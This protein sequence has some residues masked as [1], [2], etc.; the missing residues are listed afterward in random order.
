MNFSNPNTGAFVWSRTAKDI[1]LANAASGSSILFTVLL[2]GTD[3]ASFELTAISGQVTLRFREILEAVLPKGDDSQFLSSSSFRYSNSVAIR[4]ELDGSTVTTASMVCFRGGSD[5][6]SPAFPH[7]SHW[8]TWKPQVTFTWAWAREILSC[9]IPSSTRVTVSAKV[10][11][12]FH[13]PV[14]ISLN[15][16][17]SQSGASIGMVDCSPAT[18]ESTANVS[19]DFMVAYDVYTGTVMAH[20]FIIRPTRLRGREFLFRNSLGVIDT[21]FISGDTSRDTEHITSRVQIGHEER[22]LSN[23]STERFKVQ[24]GGIRERRMMD[25]WQEFLRSSERYVLLQGDVPRRIVVDEAELDL[26][27]HQLS[28]V[29]V[30]YHYAQAFTGRYYNDSELE[31]Y[32]YSASE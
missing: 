32:E 12:A 16:F 27:E 25:Q 8:L 23:N 19:D 5:E 2:N 15:T 17:T 14:T 10:Y 3:T 21:L 22:E 29:S 9:I 7:T 11:Y 4:A 26:T 20:R 18:V 1:T 28:S 31:A 13:S 30:T 24:S 6:L